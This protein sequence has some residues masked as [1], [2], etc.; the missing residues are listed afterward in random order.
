MSRNERSEIEAEVERLLQPVKTAGTLKSVVSVGGEDYF[1]V[2][3]AAMASVPFAM[4]KYT[5]KSGALQ[6]G[7]LVHYEA[8]IS[9]LIGQNSFKGIVGR[10]LDIHGILE[11][12]EGA[13]ATQR[14]KPETES[15]WPLVLVSEQWSE[16]SGGGLEV[17]E[18]RYQLGWDENYES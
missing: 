18:Q 13:L 14:I 7:G 9:L 12:T 16:I 6:P 15:Y 4:I 3:Q 2:L 10:R 5:G 11:A 17:W 8:E 1:R